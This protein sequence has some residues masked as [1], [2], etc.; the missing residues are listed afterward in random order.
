MKAALEVLAAG[1]VPLAGARSASA[2][3]PTLT[4]AALTFAA[5]APTAPV[6]QPAPS[7][8]LGTPN[9]TGNPHELQRVAFPCP[10]A[11]ALWNG[12]QA[13]RAMDLVVEDGAPP[14]EATGHAGTAVTTM[15]VI[16][17]G[18][19]HTVRWHTAHSPA[20]VDVV[21]VEIGRL[22]RAYTTP[23]THHGYPL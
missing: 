11:D 16:W 6:Q 17:D 4:S 5:C 9:A 14:P 12:V 2:W 7:K 23:F 1:G 22:E 10:D 3:L 15:T 20:A 19:T 21:M 18:A 8:Q 13:A